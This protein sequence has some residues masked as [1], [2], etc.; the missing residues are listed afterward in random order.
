MVTDREIPAP[1]GLGVE[2]KEQG[3]RWAYHPEFA[4][5]TR[6]EAYQVLENGKEL[7]LTKS[8]Y[9][10]DPN[11]DLVESR[12]GDRVRRW[13]W[14]RYSLPVVYWDGQECATVYRYYNRFVHEPIS[15]HT[16][17]LLAK[18]IKDASQQYVARVYQE[19]GI[20]KGLWLHVWPLGRNADTAPSTNMIGRVGSSKRFVPSIALAGFITGWTWC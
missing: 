2:G 19:V 8:E 9:Q 18:Q 10:Y 15:A 13:V 16:G 1:Q 14:N 5:P 4:Q 12:S 11:G 20:P 6:I 7:I 17:G 3:R